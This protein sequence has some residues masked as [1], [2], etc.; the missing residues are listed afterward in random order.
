MFFR[1]LSFL[2]LNFLLGIFWSN[3][4]FVFTFANSS[5]L[6]SNK[7]SFNQCDYFVEFF[8]FLSGD[9]FIAFFILLR[10][11]IIQVN[12]QWKMLRPM[13]KWNEWKKLHC[14]VACT[15]E[16]EFLNWNIKQWAIALGFFIVS[17]DTWILLERTLV[18]YFNP[19]PEWVVRIGNSI[20]ER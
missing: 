17:F 2:N 18:Q 3:F 9:F 13:N 15:L 4:C 5:H 8:S 6:I 20:K 1:S 12:E 14:L 10:T 16:L 11:S 7:F 19:K